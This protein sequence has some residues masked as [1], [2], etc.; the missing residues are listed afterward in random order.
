[1]GTLSLTVALLCSVAGTTPIRHVTVDQVDVIEYNHFYDEQGKHVLPGA[2][3]AASDLVEQGRVGRIE[4][5]FDEG[6][7]E[8]H[9]QNDGNRERNGRIM[10]QASETPQQS[11]Q[12][13]PEQ[14]T[15]AGRRCQYH[16]TVPYRLPQTAGTLE[17][18]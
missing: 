4:R 11:R 5:L 10:A 14:R 7:R 6:M 1:M 9:Q 15:K 18:P 13:H 12:C 8:R 16:K 2:L 17:Y 3:V